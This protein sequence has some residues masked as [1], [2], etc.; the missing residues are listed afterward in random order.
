MAPLEDKGADPPHTPPLVLFENI[1]VNL[2]LSLDSETIPASVNSLENSSGIHESAGQN[3]G[4]GGNN[5]IS[6]SYTFNS[7]AGQIE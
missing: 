6:S 5:T 7:G 4:G 1:E 2:N 3:T